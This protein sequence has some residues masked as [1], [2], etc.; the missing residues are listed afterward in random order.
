MKWRKATCG[1]DQQAAA[2]GIDLHVRLHLGRTGQPPADDTH[3]GSARDP[4]RHLKARNGTHAIPLF[5]TISCPIPA[6]GVPKYRSHHSRGWRSKVADPQPA[7]VVV[8]Q[9][10]CQFSGPKGLVC[11]SWRKGAFLWRNARRQISVGSRIGTPPGYSLKSCAAAASAPPPSASPSPPMRCGG[12]STT[13][14]ARSAPRCSR[15]TFT[16]PI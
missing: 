1:T 7:V 4:R 15:G 2:T 11:T 16:A 12:E 6:L 9:R 3:I 13:S 14:S 5:R 10:F 8:Y